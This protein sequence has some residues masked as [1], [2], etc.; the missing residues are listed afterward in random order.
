MSEKKNDITSDTSKP[1]QPI[2]IFYSYSH[3]DEDLRNELEKHLSVLKRN[4]VIA[5]WHDRKIVPGAEWGGEIDKHLETADIILLLVS[6]DFIASDY[7][8]EIEMKRAIEHHAQRTAR[9]IPIIL[10]KCDWRDAPFGKLQALPKDGKPIKTW[11]DIDEAFT[12]VVAGLKRTIAEITGEPLAGPSSAPGSTTT[13]PTLVSQA[14]YSGMDDTAEIE[15]PRENME[16]PASAQPANTP[17]KDKKSADDPAV[18]SAVITSRRTLIG[19][20]LTAVLATVATISAAGINKCANAS[21]SGPSSPPFIGRIINK[22]TEEKVRGAKVSLEGEGVPSVAYS[23]SEG[24][25][26]FPVNDPNKEIHLRIE[27]DQYENFDLQV[28]PA[29]NQGIQDVRL[30]PK[31][32][33]TADLSGTVVDSNDSPIQEANVTLNDVIGMR[34]VET[35]GDGQFTLK[36]VPRKYGEMVRVRVVKEGYQPRTEDVVLG[37]TPPRIKLKRKR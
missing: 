26:S 32:D 21:Q 29:K 33:K 16:T 22:N 11:N 36:D 28:T 25:F 24:I 8:Y 10:R 17:E 34:P 20:I 30:T 14:P 9:V 13:G 23:D 31:T 7:C 35:D 6:S 15:R 12:D 2:E 19:T 5:G 1:P 37:K 18:E 3:K 27:A 4:G